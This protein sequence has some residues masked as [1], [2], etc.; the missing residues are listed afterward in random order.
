MPQGGLGLLLGLTVCRE[1]SSTQ[2]IPLL[3]RGNA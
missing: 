1:F 2:A 3:A